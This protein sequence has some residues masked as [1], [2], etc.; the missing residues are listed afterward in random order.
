MS[1]WKP[2]QLVTIEG[3]IYRI[4]YTP[5]DFLVCDKCELMRNKPRAFCIYVSL[6]NKI[7]N[8]YIMHSY[9]KQVYPKT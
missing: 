7:D 9:F 5:K 8:K 2:G 6:C 1:K 4:R 3:K